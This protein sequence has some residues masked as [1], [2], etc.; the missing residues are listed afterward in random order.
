MGPD[1][2]PTWLGRGTVL[3]GAAGLAVA[4]VNVL[5]SQP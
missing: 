5:H 2:L 3:G 1:L 4:L